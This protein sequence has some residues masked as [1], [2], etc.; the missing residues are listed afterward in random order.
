M[1]FQYIYYV[2]CKKINIIKLN[3]IYDII[4]YLIFCNKNIF[5]KLILKYLLYNYEII[6]F[7]LIL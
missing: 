6:I 3:L 2:L 4:Q 5:N 1:Y 7:N